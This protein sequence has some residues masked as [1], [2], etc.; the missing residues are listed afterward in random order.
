[1]RVATYNVHD[2]V[3]REGRFDPGTSRQVLVEINPDV[4]ALQEVTL[5]RVGDLIGRL[6][7]GTDLQAI[8]S[9]LAERGVGILPQPCADRMIALVMAAIYRNF[10]RP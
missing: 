5:D 1:M 10:R 2:C 3:G 4:I 7:K 6:E 9:R 8:D